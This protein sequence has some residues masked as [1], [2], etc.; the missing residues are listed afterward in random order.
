LE[1][2]IDKA[3]CRPSPLPL[4][5]SLF[6]ITSLPDL[7]A[8]SLF[9]TLKDGLYSA[10]LATKFYEQFNKKE[11]L[12]DTVTECAGHKAR[13]LIFLTA[14]NRIIGLYIL[15]AHGKTYYLTGINNRPD[16][17]P[18]SRAFDLFAGRFRTQAGQYVPLGDE[19]AGTSPASGT[20]RP[21]ATPTPSPKPTRTFGDDF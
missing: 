5:S 16:F 2:L 20:S 15:N 10:L 11:K 4:I 3:S 12:V 6:A 13:K 1:F 21:R 8:L 14:D 9:S 18:F 19:P 7:A 17:E